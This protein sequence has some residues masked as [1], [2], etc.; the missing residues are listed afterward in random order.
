MRL[1]REGHLSRVEITTKLEDLRRTDV[2]WENP[3]EPH[4]YP[5]L[6]FTYPHFGGRRVWYECPSCQRRAM[7]LYDENS[8]MP[9]ASPKY[10][11]RTCLGLKYRSQ[12]RGT[13]QRMIAKMRWVQ[14]Q[15]QADCPNH[16]PRYMRHKRFRK[17]AEAYDK[18]SKRR[19][20]LTF[21]Q[22]LRKFPCLLLSP[23]QK[24]EHRQ[25][26]LAAFESDK[27]VTVTKTHPEVP[28]AAAEAYSIICRNNGLTDDGAHPLDN[29][30]QV[31]GKGYF[32]K[33]RG[34]F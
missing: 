30:W 23:V 26:I 5:S 25:K 4:G 29:V 3:N 21:M 1:R 8:F 33:R 16:R 14:E 18:A 28:D 9:N 2:D 13:H 12:G 22:V 32:P 11:C 6:T 15:L 27:S 20:D 10:A 19:Y 34:A 7:S 17:L 31:L 24:A